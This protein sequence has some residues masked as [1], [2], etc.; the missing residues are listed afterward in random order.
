LESNEPFSWKESWRKWKEE[1][2]EF[3]AE[4]K[5][6]M[7]RRKGEFMKGK[8]KGKG[9]CKG[10]WHWWD[11]GIDGADDGANST[12]SDSIAS[13]PAAS[14]SDAGDAAPPGLELPYAGAPWWWKGKGRGKGKDWAP[15][16]W[17]WGPWGGAMLN[18]EFSQHFWNF[19]CEGWPS[20]GHW[21]P[22]ENA[23]FEHM[24]TPVSSE[25][26]CDGDNVGKVEHEQV[27]GNHP[28]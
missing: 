13:V 18:P 2:A 24:T 5:R 11:G 1:K 16:Q 12:M 25:G 7:A 9:K 15:M 19:G 23:G 27:E 28:N 14:A 26:R 21:G 8:A 17:P 4:W 6:E 10:R 3:K 22:F 20:D